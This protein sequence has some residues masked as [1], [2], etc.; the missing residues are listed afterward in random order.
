MSY[1]PPSSRRSS[2]TPAARTEPVCRVQE[3]KPATGS[4]PLL[5]NVTVA[6]RNG[7]VIHNVP[8]FRAENGGISVGTPTAPLVDREGQQLRDENGKRK[9][10]RVVSLATPEARARWQEAITAALFVAGIGGWS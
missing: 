2:L 6:F 7:M 10:G 9:Y 3:W 1:D 5:G 4:G 8:V